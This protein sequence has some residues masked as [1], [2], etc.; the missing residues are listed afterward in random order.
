MHVHGHS[1]LVMFSS[2]V[3]FRFPTYREEDPSGHM[4]VCARCR[5]GKVCS[6]LLEKTLN[7]HQPIHP[8]VDVKEN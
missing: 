7:S 5:R 3:G 2:L 4:G 6:L 1:I 8:L